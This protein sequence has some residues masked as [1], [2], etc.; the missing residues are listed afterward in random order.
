MK[1]AANSGFRSGKP[2]KRRTK[3]L[4]IPPK[5]KVRVWERDGG[6]C[7]LC[8][9]PQAAPNAHYIARSHGGLGIEENI[10]T[11]CLNCHYEFDFGDHR[12]DCAV[13]VREH[14]KSCYPDWNEG[15]LIYRK[16]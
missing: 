8:G 12:E 7:V 9:T 1:E 16:K 13:A 15:N 6:R 10:V 4:A 14:L 5:V 11:L 3:A 2:V